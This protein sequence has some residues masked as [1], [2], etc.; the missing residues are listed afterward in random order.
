M[1]NNPGRTSPQGW[2]DGSAKVAP[3]GSGMQLKAHNRMGGSKRKKKED[4]GYVERWVMWDWC[5]GTYVGHVTSLCVI[6]AIEVALGA[7]LWAVAG[8][9]TELSGDFWESIW[10]SWIMFVDPGT[11]TGVPP[12]DGRGIQT[13]AVILSLCGFTYFVTILGVVVDMIRI[14]MDRLTMVYNRVI[15]NDH[16]LA[17]GWSD[18][19]LF[20]VKE[21]ALDHQNSPGVLDLVILSDNDR[22]ETE[23][24][25]KM[26]MNK[27]PDLR[28]SVRV[29]CWE[30]DPQ[31]S[32]DLLR[33]SIRSAKNIIILGPGGDSQRS[34]QEVLR[35][36]L[37]IQG[38]PGITVGGDPIKGQII[39]EVCVPANLPIVKAIGADVMGIVARDMVNRVMV[40]SALLP[41][42][43][44]VWA[45]L[46]TFS[47]NEIYVLKLPERYS[48]HQWR[49]VRGKAINA[50]VFGMYSEDGRVIISPDDDQII[51]A[52]DE[53]LV[54]ADDDEFIWDDKFTSETD[55]REVV[56]C[57]ASSTEEEYSLVH[58]VDTQSPKVICIIGWASDTAEI[59]RLINRLTA[60]GSHV[61]VLSPMSLQKRIFKLMNANLTA[62]DYVFS[63]RDGDDDAAGQTVVM[64]EMPELTNLQVTHYVGSP[65]VTHQLFQLPVDQADTIMILAD[66]EAEEAID[67]DSAVL[68]SLLHISLRGDTMG[69][70]TGDLKPLCEVS[71]WRSERIV[72]KSD[73]LN[74]KGRFVRSSEL[75]TGV[76]ALCAHNPI[77]GELM[78]DLVSLREGS[79]RVSQLEVTTFVEHGHKC[80]FRDMAS[81][82]RTKKDTLIGYVKRSDGDV[83]AVRLNP[84]NKNSVVEWEK[85]DLLLVMTPGVNMLTEHNE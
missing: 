82:V 49:E 25:I 2:G 75:E 80:S 62:K 30:G 68:T 58:D 61:H 1:P 18:K 14:Q 66:D 60:K 8:G 50:I 11:H 55:N 7:V 34:D 73:V 39:A 44:V 22:F 9:S 78:R 33:V 74:T 31:E 19:T 72:R 42:I 48:G 43:G 85:G 47:G 54:I 20:L 64:P 40:L 13:V 32:D 6:G 35:T 36:I 16:I 67:S 28:S 21:L 3:E 76:F 41:A 59:L 10:A 71:D 52:A 24:I 65:V 23:R 17:L 77:M 26:F 53:I 70:T 27:Y 12:S 51:T 37:A 81:K 69:D 4:N 84:E 45:D 57:L 56:N 15:C 79:A 38:L 29:T 63:Y 46:M 5:L 83:E